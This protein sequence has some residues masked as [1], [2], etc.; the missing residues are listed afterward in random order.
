MHVHTMYMYINLLSL[1]LGGYGEG[2]RRRAEED[3]RERE[4]GEGRRER[5]KDSVFHGA[6]LAHV[7]SLPSS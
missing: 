6:I 4:G 1:P 7:K 2:G 3:G 5:G